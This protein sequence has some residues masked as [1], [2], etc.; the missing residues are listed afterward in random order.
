MWNDSSTIGR[1]APIRSYR[2]AIE[3]V[4]RLED[5]TAYRGKRR[6]Y[7]P[8]IRLKA[9]SDR[10]RLGHIQAHRL[11]NWRSPL[12]LLL[13]TIRSHYQFNTRSGNTDRTRIG[14]VS[15]LYDS[16]DIDELGLAAGSVVD[17][18]S[19]FDDGERHAKRFVVV[20][21][22]I[23]AGCAAA[24]FPEANPLVPL[25]NYAKRSGT[26]ASKS[27]VI[28]LTATGETAGKFD[29]VD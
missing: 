3:R 12:R 6:F 11:K 27:I 17:I 23:P 19:H 13:P 14:P 1:V 2:D 20:P 5:Y 26:P 9:C 22:A 18:T 21:Y 24:Y 4:Y 28:S 8:N 29:P 15:D 25:G 10:I 7:L 16:S